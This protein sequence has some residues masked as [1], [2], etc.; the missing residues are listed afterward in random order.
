MN[1]KSKKWKKIFLMLKII[2]VIILIFLVIFTFYRNSE[3]KA[4]V[5]KKYTDKV[6][7]SKL[8]L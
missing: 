2:Y 5:F 1:I 6:N 3:K 4:K 8:S 7:I